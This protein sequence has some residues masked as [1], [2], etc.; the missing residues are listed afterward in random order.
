MSTNLNT[1]TADSAVTNR[2]FLQRTID[3]YLR[4][5]LELDAVLTRYE[6]KQFANKPILILALVSAL[7]Y[8]VFKQEWIFLAL[9]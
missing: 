2:N 8:F 5:P 1:P 4:S 3:Q 7:A 9:T 6:F